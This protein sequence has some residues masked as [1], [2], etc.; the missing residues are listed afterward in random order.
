MFYQERETQHV[1]AHAMYARWISVAIEH[2]R[3][4]RTTYREINKLELFN[5]PLKVLITHARL[6][7]WP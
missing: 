2:E 3:E 1:R 4:A 7:S 5:V 6:A